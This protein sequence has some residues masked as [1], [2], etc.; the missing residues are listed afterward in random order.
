MGEV[1]SWKSAG[2]LKRVGRSA[3]R[4][5]YAAQVAGPADTAAC[6]CDAGDTRPP[7]HCC[8][9]PRHT[10]AAARHMPYAP[11]DTCAHGGLGVG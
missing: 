5:L 3:P 9:V 8:A 11:A 2:P 6:G 7:H 1:A 4:H 10:A